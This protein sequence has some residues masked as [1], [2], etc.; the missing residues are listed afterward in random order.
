MARLS[1][2]N[3]A[4]PQAAIVPK[5]Q[6]GAWLLELAKRLEAFKLDYE[7]AV[8]QEA[9][10]ES[11]NHSSELYD[12]IRYLRRLSDAH[13]MRTAIGAREVKKIND[14]ATEEARVFAANI[15]EHKAAAQKAI[16][17]GGLVDDMVNNL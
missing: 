10:S 2:E 12:I 8:S 15:A 1:K 7:E 9:D 11:D 4:I 16:Q 17:G 5:T 6:Y 3:P 14:A 13:E